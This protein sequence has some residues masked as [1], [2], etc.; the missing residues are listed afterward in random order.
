MRLLSVLT[1]SL[2]ALFA[3]A[4][5][6]EEKEKDKDKDALSG[7]FKRKAGDITCKIAFKK[8]SK[9]DFIVEVGDALCVMQCKYTQGKDGTVKC[10]VEKF[11]KKGPFPVTK[12]KGYEFSMKVGAIKDGKMTVSDFK[13]EEVDEPAKQAIEGEY[14]TSSD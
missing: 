5:V 14:E 12:E 9:L 8:E 11:E 1:L 13:G 6:A 3:A 2:A 7:T 10:V 4:A